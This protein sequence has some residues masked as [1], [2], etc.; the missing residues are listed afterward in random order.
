M[1][2]LIIDNESRHTKEI[3]SSC[4][5]SLNSRPHV[6]PWNEIDFSTIQNYNKIILSGSSHFS[7]RTYPD[8]YKIQK[9]IIEIS[10]IPILG[11]C[12]GFELICGSLGSTIVRYDKKVQGFHS[13][14]VI[15]NDILTEGYHTMNVYEGH[16]L[17]CENPAHPLISLGNSI[18]GTEIV[19]HKQKP[20]YGVQ[21]HPEVTQPEN[22]GPIILH[23]FLTL[24]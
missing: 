21:F 22:D 5:A 16:H 9:L 14:Q 17:A 1:H 3:V 19:K 23:R 18:Y 12:A 6:V 8:V 10:T 20:I 13:I 4:I 15:G 7:V 24:I 2:V 11:I